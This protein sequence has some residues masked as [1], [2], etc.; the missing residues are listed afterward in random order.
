MAW[1]VDEAAQCG[2]RGLGSTGEDKAH[3][4]SLESAG[5][6]PDPPE[7]SGFARVHYCLGLLFLVVIIWVA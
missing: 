2:Q 3:R 1:R 6:R 4:P 7:K 5:G